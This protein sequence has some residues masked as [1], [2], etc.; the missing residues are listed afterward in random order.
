MRKVA[1]F[2]AAHNTIVEYCGFW[3]HV[4]PLQSYFGTTWT[5]QSIAIIRKVAGAAA[6]HDV[7]VEY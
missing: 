2:A 1:G 4:S 6:A 5:Y 3:S 7:I